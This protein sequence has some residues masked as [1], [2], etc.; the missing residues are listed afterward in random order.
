VSGVF[1]AGALVWAKAGVYLENIP[2]LPHFIWD[3]DKTNLHLPRLLHALA[4]VV[5]LSR[6]PMER[7]I[8]GSRVMQPLA[9]MGRQSLAVFACGTVL[10]LLAQALR[11]AFG[12]AIAL[13][14]LLIT[15]G[16]MLQMALAWVLEWNRQGQVKRGAA[17]QAD[18]APTG[19]AR[20]PG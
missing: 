20:A 2:G 11:I 12:G 13:D 14:M 16:L 5:V 17:A 6:L 9:L 4:L 10:S 18:L 3:F 15:S 8:A 1:L 19:Y 7:W